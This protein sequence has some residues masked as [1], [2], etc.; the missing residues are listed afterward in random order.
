[1]EKKF[2]PTAG[3]KNLVR[4]VT[5]TGEKPKGLFLPRNWRSSKKSEGATPVE[6]AAQDLGVNI[7]VPKQQG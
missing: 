5:D 2:E 7:K 3:L 4:S 1:M 6:R